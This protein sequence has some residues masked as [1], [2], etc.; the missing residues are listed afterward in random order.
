[1]TSDAYQIALLSFLAF[2]LA[3]LVALNIM[4]SRVNRLSGKAP[5]KLFWTLDRNPAKPLLI[6]R[7]HQR[8]FPESH[9]GRMYWTLV[10][11]AVIFFVLM[12]YKAEKARG[13][14]PS[15][16]QADFN[17]VRSVRGN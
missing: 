6:Y 11:M 15:T 7:E 10:S 4:R 16:Q 5:I 12:I 2:G 1:M 9:L 8:L 17:D 14:L 3:S 13:E